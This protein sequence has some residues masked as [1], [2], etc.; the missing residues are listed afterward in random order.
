MKTPTATG[1]KASRPGI[2]IRRWI[3]GLLLGVIA[4]I[5]IVL[6]CA[7]G[8]LD[9]IVKAG[10]E[11]Y[12]SRSVGTEVAVQSVRIRLKEGRA[13]IHGLTVGNPAGFREKNAFSLGEIAAD[14]DVRSVAEEVKI[15][16]EIVV[17]APQIT[18]EMNQDRTFNL[19]VILKNLAASSPSAKKETAR[20]R[21][22]DSK[23]SGKPEDRKEP[24]LILE[25]VL[26]RDG[27]IRGRF[28]FGGDRES[29]LRLPTVEMRDLGAPNGAT[30][31]ELTRQII[32]ELS[33]RAMAEVRKKAV[34]AA[35]DKVKSEAESAVRKKILKGF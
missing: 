6:L 29:T 4:V 34:S 23:A 31:T 35:K 13:E 11:K 12:G 2:R 22:G 3:S 1:K 25:R 27:V 24:L 15:I 21:T 26:F 16:E 7:I 28:E 14:I 33:R 17:A 8:N 32:G 5:I 9:R 10:I 19:N 20:R 18:V 30:P